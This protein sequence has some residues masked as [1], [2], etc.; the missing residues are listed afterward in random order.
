[1][2]I[3]YAVL[4]L[5]VAALVNWASDDLTRFGGKDRPVTAS[6]TSRPTLS[7]LRWF[8]AGRPTRG[9]LAL[10]AGIELASMVLYVIL[11]LR[12]GATTSFVIAAVSC[13]Y[14]L[15]VALIDLKHRLVLNVLVYPAIVITLVA[16]LI[17]GQLSMTIVGGVFAFMI[18]YGT[19]LVKPGT[20]GGGD[21]KLATL[22]GIA[23]GFPN[24][25]WVLIVGAGSAAVIAGYFLLTAKGTIRSI[26][27]APFLC[28]GALIAL[29][30]NPFLT[31]MAFR[32]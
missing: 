10:A 3:L 17:A 24:I 26:P 27:Y 7:L 8:Q 1:M 4:G 21:V 32:Q 25:L 2:I 31:L 14:L 28:L 12:L 19:A 11:G 6:A 15:L 20:L 18:F 22:I 9:T 23:F 13:A 30:Y 29:F 16:H 5:V